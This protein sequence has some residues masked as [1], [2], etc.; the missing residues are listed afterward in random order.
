MKIDKNTLI[1]FILM[2]AVFFGF[3]FYEGKVQKERAT[4]MQK[5]Q[6][7]EAIAQQKSDSIKNIEEEKKIAEKLNEA[8]SK[9]EE[10]K[11]DELL[12]NTDAR[13]NG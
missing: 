1:G 4:Q 11:A 2:A 8:I 9:A 7:I 13:C 12:D 6:A 10:E 5:E 3:M